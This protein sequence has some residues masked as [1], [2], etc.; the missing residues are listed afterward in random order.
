MEKRFKNAWI[1]KACCKVGT[2]LY[3]LIH[4][5]PSL[6]YN[7]VLNPGLGWSHPICKANMKTTILKRQEKREAKNMID[8]ATL[9]EVPWTTSV[10]VGGSWCRS[11]DF[12]RHLNERGKKMLQK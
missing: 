8:L 10:I 3:T 6:P 9:K 12:L 1:R 7:T 2:R 5:C 4:S 11:L